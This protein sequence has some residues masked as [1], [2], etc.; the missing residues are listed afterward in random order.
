MVP[1][2]T[3]FLSNGRPLS[4]VKTEGQEDLLLSNS[5]PGQVYQLAQKWVEQ[6]ARNSTSVQPFKMTIDE[7][8]C[9]SEEIA[10]HLENPDWKTMELITASCEY[11][12]HV[13]YFEQKQI[14][15]ES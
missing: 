7:V 14:G 4:L 1:S 5:Q 6:D 15:L 2:D 3:K 10:Q 11:R 9:N 8:L 12:N 13:Q